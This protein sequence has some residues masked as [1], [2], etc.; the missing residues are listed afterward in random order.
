MRALM[1]G[2]DAARGQALLD[3]LSVRLNEHDDA[4]VAR[5]QTRGDEVAG[6]FSGVRVGI[7]MN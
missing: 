3:G 7:K 6:V 2:F 1:A 4:G 5:E